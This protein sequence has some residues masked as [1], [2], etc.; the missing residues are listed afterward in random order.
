MENSRKLSGSKTS[1]KRGSES[2]GLKEEHY[3]HKEGF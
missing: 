2:K 3:H 1:F